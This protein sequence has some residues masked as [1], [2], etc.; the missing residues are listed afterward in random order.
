MGS[1]WPSCSRWLLINMQA[2]TA[3]LALLM[4]SGV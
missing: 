4:A 3:C 2:S 1:I